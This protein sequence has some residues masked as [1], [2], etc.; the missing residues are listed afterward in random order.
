MVKTPRI[1][2]NCFLIPF[3]M[4]AVFLLVIKSIFIIKIKKIDIILSMGGYAPVPICL[5]GLILRKKIFIYEP[6]Q[7]LGNSNRFFYQIV[8]K[9]FAIIKN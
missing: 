7:V 1:F 5:A 6:N 9:F 2:G 8:K 3:K 4:I